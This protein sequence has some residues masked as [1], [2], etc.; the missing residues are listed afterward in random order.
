ME[1]QQTPAIV[2]LIDHH[3]GASRVSQLL[4]G[5]PF[6]QEVQRWKGRGWASPMHI[7]ALKPLLLDGMTL[8]DLHADR[9]VA[10]QAAGKVAA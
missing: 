5:K 4:G 9:Q 10:R 7:L 8:E 6:Y 3:G 2:R 1:A